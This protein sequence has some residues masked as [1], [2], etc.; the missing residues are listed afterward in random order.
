MYNYLLIVVSALIERNTYGTS[1]EGEDSENKSGEGGG[2]V[3][4]QDWLALGLLSIPE[5][6]SSGR[7][8]V[9]VC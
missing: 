5:M 4:D 7:G 1:F 8:R 6:V 2:Q 3:A 9:W